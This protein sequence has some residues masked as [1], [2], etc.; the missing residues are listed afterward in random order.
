MSDFDAI[1]VGSK[2][3]A[4]STRAANYAADLKEAGAL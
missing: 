4:L 3:V 1:I 2:S